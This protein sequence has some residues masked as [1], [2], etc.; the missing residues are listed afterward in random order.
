M[1]CVQ[2]R[3]FVLESETGRGRARGRA[4]ALAWAVGNDDKEG[5]AIGSQLWLAP[6][7]KLS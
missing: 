4:D 7:P 1:A 3:R 2:K 5:V 6:W